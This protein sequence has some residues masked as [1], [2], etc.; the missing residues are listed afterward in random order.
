MNTPD[1][2]LRS[3][4]AFGSGGHPSTQG[5]LIALDR[6]RAALSP[7]R[8]LDMGCGS[9]ILSLAAAFFWPNATV[10]A[11]DIAQAAVD[12]TMENASANG[13][14]GRILALRSEGYGE[15]LITAHAPYDL[16]LCNILAEPIIRMAGDLGSHLGDQGLAVL[17]GILPWLEADV[18][19]A[20]DMAGLAPR[21][22]IARE[23]WNTL[24]LQKT[25]IVTKA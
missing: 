24:I 20:H 22:C 9:G 7:R 13:A 17:A 6:L 8:I 10:I 19:A 12:A 14:A 4:A 16:I 21:E 2:L 25:A 5:G 15:A 23:G 18:L 11:V 3:G 1:F